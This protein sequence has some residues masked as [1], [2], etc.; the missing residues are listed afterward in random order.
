VLVLCWFC[1][2]SGLVQCWFGVGS[3][4]VLCWFCVGSVLVLCRFCVGSVL[5]QCWFC[6]GSVLV[7]CWFSVGSA[8]VLRWFCV[9]S[10]S[11][12]TY[13]PQAVAHR[14]LKL[15]DQQFGTHPIDVPMDVLFGRPSQTSGREVRLCATCTLC[16]C[17]CL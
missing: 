1:V 15:T 17:V 12:Y 14:H 11:V 13:I 16:V 4:L 5:V 9:G 2:G 6:V 7:Q 3:V 10:V 8:W